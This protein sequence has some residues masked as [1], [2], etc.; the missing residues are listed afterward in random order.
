MITCFDNYKIALS[1]IKKRSVIYQSLL[2]KV[3]FP[4]A[5]EWG[6]K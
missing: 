2:S 5:L 6:A 4:S 1:Q 3:T